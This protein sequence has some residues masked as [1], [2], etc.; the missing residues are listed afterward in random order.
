MIEVKILLEPN[1]PSLEAA[2]AELLNDGWE[3]ERA[4][5][6]NTVMPMIIL[7]RGKKQR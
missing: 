3:I 4:V 2:L 7:V 1:V 6:T 5:S